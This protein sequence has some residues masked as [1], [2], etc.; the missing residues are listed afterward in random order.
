[1]KNKKVKIVA[2]LG[3]AS[4]STEMIESLASAGVDV[5]RIN[6]SHQNK[7]GIMDLVKKIHQ[8]EQKLNK[9]LSIMGDLGGLK[10]RIGDIE[11]DTFLT[12]GDLIKISAK[13]LKGSG[14]IFSINQPSILSQLKKGME[15][16]IDDGLI[17]LIITKE[18][19]NDIVC[20]SVETGGLLLPRK[21]FYVQDISLSSIGIPEKDQEDIKLMVDLKVDALAVSF[22]ESENDVIQIRKILP[23]DSEMVLIA[24]IETKLALENIEKIID[25]SDGVL[26]ARG[27]LGLAVP[28]AEVPILQKQLIAVCLRKATPVITATQMLESM[29]QSPFPTRAETT[30]VANAILD[31]T[32]AIMLSDETA[33]GKYPLQAVEMMSMIIK[34]TSPHI[35]TRQF[36]DEKEIPH[37]VSSAAGLIADNVGAKLILVFTQSGFSALQVARQ[38]SSQEVIVALTPSRKTLKLLNFCWGIYP[39]MIGKTNNLDHAFEQSKECILNNE[40]IKLEKGDPYVMVMGIP[41]NHPGHT[42]IIHVDTIE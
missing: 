39:K 38:R 36:H 19:E 33:T 10:V 28:I 24:K 25:V 42:N 8:A 3:P 26:I 27:D 21:G 40:I 17:K 9:P 13:P 32:D 11:N 1:M 23:P 15:I 2:T 29:T 30:D 12:S 4:Q 7:D 18:I 20:A 34:T 41:F 37:A 14:E 35:V 31:G 16:L 5:F 6:L 22:V